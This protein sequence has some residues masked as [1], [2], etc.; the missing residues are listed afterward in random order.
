MN[1]IMAPQP[2]IGRAAELARLQALTAPAADDLDRAL[3]VLGEAGTGKT[4]LLAELTAHARS[5]GLRVLSAAG[6]ERESVRPFAGLRQLLRPVLIE[7]LALPGPDAEELR[8]A[9]GPA[10]PGHRPDRDVV[11]SALLELLTDL[12]QYGP[13]RPGTGVLVA[14]DDAQW[15]DSASLDVLALAADRLGQE[16]AAIILAARGEVP[17]AEVAQ[18]L[19]ELRLSPL[20]PADARELLDSQPCPPQGRARAQVLAQA[21]GHP[22]ALIELA[23]AICDDPAAAH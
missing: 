20:A 16:Q 12:A 5:R 18:G 3:V 13:A 6:R 22:L 15:M 21:A 4:A 14:V 11:A 1:G 17:P 8:A 19:P 9:L 10:S 23:R 2:L 7:L